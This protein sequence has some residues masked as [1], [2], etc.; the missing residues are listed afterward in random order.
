[1]NSNLIVEVIFSHKN[2]K[3]FQAS[4][5]RSYGAFS[6]NYFNLFEVSALSIFAFN[7]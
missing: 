4:Q 1:M 3:M 2:K 7:A 5:M 6:F